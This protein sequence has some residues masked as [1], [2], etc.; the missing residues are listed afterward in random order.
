MT[1]TAGWVL[2]FIQVITWKDGS[3]DITSN[4]YDRVRGEQPK[5]F[6]T[7]EACQQELQNLVFADDFPYEVKIKKEGWI[8]AEG[9]QRNAITI[10]NEVTCLEIFNTPN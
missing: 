3:V 6:A 4:Q 7:Q 9:I 8:V 2:L 1:T 5:M 10:Q